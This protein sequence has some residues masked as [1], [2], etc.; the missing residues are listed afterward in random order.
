[1][2][3]LSVVGEPT[4]W[5]QTDKHGHPLRSFEN[6]RVA[7]QR[8]GI[9]CRYDMF[10]DRRL[11]AGETLGH[12]VGE[13][14]DRTCGL[15]RL[16]VCDTFEFDPG[17]DNTYEAVASLCDEHAFDP[18]VNYLGG[19]TWDGTRRLE[20]WLTSYLGATDTPLNR[21][22]GRLMLIAAVRRARQPG[23]K[24][25][26]IV[27][28]EGPQN[29][30]KSTAVRILAGDENFSD[31]DILH[32]DARAQ[33]EAVQGVWL[34]EIGELAG[35]RRTEVEKVKSF[36]S[37]QVDRA[38]PAYG[39]CRVDQPRR[40]TFVATYNP[41]GEGYLRDATGNRRFWPVPTGEIDLDALRR[42]RDQLWA[43]AAAKEAEPG[44]SLE[45]E[46]SLW[47]DAAVEQEA[48]REHDPWVDV[49]RGVNGEP[50]PAGSGD[51]KEE[52]V[53]ASRLL[54]AVLQIRVADQ[55]AAHSKRLAACMRQLGW[56]GPRKTRIK[57]NEQSV[58][59][60]VRP[61]PTDEEP[62]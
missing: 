4:A 5:R 59:G 43:E 26:N 49:L 9:E 58:R 30:G 47:G 32:L 34:F 57:G 2:P 50:S 22:I 41:D 56:E 31:Q 28:L 19:L 39:R 10:H 6:T 52:R 51:G 24:F 27:V 8:L 7:V 37:R 15:I 62:M 36:A 11:V 17:K 29:K 23:C 18:V 55:T 1:M 38:R 25:D 16:L 48:R 35:L 13:L 54:E 44:C 42:D 3:V 40:C 60:Y 14:S 53:C 21:A 46:R 20:T 61:V 45:L 12:L 33:Q